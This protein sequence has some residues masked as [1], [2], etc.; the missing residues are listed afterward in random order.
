MRNDTEATVAAGLLIAQ[1]QISFRS[2]A[3]HLAL[4]L[5]AIG[6]SVVL[7]SLLATESGLPM[8]TTAALGGLLLINLAWGAYAVWVLAAHR[9]LLLNHRVVAGRIAAAAAA[10]FTVGA[11]CVAA[12]LQSQASYAATVSGVFLLLVAIV[13]LVR[14]KRNFRALE[15]RRSELEARLGHAVR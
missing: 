10:A 15:L 11:A 2:R 5:V 7:G 4:L 8:R 6:A 3:A 12:T 14:A 9:T 1:V 13:L